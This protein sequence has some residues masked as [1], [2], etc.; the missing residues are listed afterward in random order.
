METF[1]TSQ[2]WMS[3]LYIKYFIIVWILVEFGY[4]VYFKE[5]HGK[6][7]EDF[8]NI[9]MDFCFPTDQNRKH[10]KMIDV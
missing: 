6:T 7:K 1:S 3:A 9:N 10:D 5:R 4:F 2:S 8:P